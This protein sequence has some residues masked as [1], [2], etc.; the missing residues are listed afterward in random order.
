[1][2]LARTCADLGA[3]P[4]LRLIDVAEA[5]KLRALDRPIC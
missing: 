3:A 5:I 1:L 2:K 4:E